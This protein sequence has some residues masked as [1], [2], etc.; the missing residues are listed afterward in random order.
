LPDVGRETLEPQELVE[1]ADAERSR[2]LGSRV[3]V[4]A[5]LLAVL[6]SIS[7]LQAEH[8]AAE[9]MLA[10]NDAV[11]WQSRASDEWAYR[12][13][14]SIKLHLE[15]LRP[16]APPDAERQRADIAA[17]EERAHAA[18]ARRD[19]ANQEAVAHFARHRRFAVATSL[20]QIAIVLETVAA[21][22]QRRSVWWAG[23]ALG[24]LAAVA[25]LNGY[26]GLV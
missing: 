4:T 3:A 26:L 14:K 12:Q 21:V 8:G 16:V 9:S 22:L 13:A 20:F 6:A 11:L 15:E 24:A 17:S 2:G 1:L 19:D 23:V 18:E 5:A 10:K 25:F 7:M